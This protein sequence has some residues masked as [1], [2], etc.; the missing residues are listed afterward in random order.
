MVVKID[1]KVILGFIATSLFGILTWALI[2]LVDIKA[3]L[4]GAEAELFH[5]NKQI[6]RIYGTFQQK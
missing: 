5:I 2:T 1:L 3:T 6:G 4:A